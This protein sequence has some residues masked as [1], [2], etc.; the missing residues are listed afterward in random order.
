MGGV[1]VGEG[2][3][4]ITESRPSDLIR[5]KL[6]FMKPF[7]ATNTAGFTF[8]PEGNQTA[9]TRSMTGENNFIAK[10]VHL[11]MNMDKGGWSIREGAGANETGGGSSGKAIARRLLSPKG[12][13]TWSKK[14]HPLGVGLVNS[15]RLSFESL[16]TNG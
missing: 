15:L 1:L 3:M 16:R 14:I 10:A 13:E 11:F 6:E 4:T 12:E 5:I 9:V 2:W 8:K 7:R